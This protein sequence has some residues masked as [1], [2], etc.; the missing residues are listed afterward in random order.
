MFR[1]IIEALIHYFTC[2]M[3][4]LELNVSY[5]KLKEQDNPE[6]GHHPCALMSECRAEDTP[7]LVLSHLLQRHVV[8]DAQR[9]AGH[10]AAR[11]EDM[12]HT[13]LKMVDV[14]VNACGDD[15]TPVPDDNNS[16]DF[17]ESS[18]QLTATC[19][20]VSEPAQPST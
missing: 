8:L 19:R 11:A 1:H 18:S 20:C 16:F 12:S 15:N 10:G 14:A 7:L 3:P 6:A 5:S 9:K 17:F 4:M 13:V 2:A